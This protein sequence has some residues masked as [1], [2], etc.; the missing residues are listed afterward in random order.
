MTGLLSAL[1]LAVTTLAAPTAAPSQC[2]TAPAK[3][4]QAAD[5]GEGGGGGGTDATCIA[6]CGPLNPWVSCSYASTCT[7]VDANCPSQQGYVVCDGITY[8]CTPC[9]TDGHIR[10]VTT[11]PNCS[12]EDGGSTPK[13]RYKCVN[14]TWEYQFSFCGGPFCPIW[15]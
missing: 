12:C 10:N 9:C 8:H 14:G 6:D 1:V 13:D 5:L 2:A 11:G 15:P 7:A 4:F 3:L